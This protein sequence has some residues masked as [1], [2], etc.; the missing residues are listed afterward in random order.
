MNIISVIKRR[1]P[2][3]FVNIAHGIHSSKDVTFK[4]KLQNPKFALKEW[5]ASVHG[6]DSETSAILSANLERLDNLAENGPLSDSDV[7]SR[8]NTAPGTP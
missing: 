4:L 2:T 8:S 1:A 6:N 3:G 5:R 7:V